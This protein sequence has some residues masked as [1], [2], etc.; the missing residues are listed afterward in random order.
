M[1]T[2]TSLGMSSPPSPWPILYTKSPEE[3]V[4]LGSDIILLISGGR[5]FSSL[6]SADSIWKCSGNI[7]ESFW[8]WRVLK[9]KILFKCSQ[10]ISIILSFPKT[11]SGPLV[12]R[13]VVWEACCAIAA[14]GRRP[15]FV[16]KGGRYSGQQN[17]VN[18]NLLYAYKLLLHTQ[19]G[20]NRWR[21]A[22]EEVLGRPGTSSH[23]MFAINNCSTTHYAPMILLGR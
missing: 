11:P 1:M 2:A 18:Y 21:R 8:K 17:G 9:K 6:H 5:T 3:R 23:S 7:P 4:R 13:W 15:R 14:S 22:E 20:T 19:R 16:T 10:N 12:I